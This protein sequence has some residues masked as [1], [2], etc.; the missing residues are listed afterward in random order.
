M[1]VIK[2]DA[3]KLPTAAD[4]KSHM[5][6]S[7]LSVAV[8]DQEIRF[9]NRGAFP[10]IS[11]PVGMASA[12]AMMPFLKPMLGGPPPG[13][14]GPAADNQTAAPAAGAAAP[15]DA[16]E[17]SLKGRARGRGP[18]GRSAARGPD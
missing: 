17:G 14:P 11:I 12:G 4:L 10:D 15:A 6:P 9:V 2:V 5:F 8:T 13:S 18:G 7:T 3:D 16:P 1:I